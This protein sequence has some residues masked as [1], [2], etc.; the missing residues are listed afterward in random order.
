[1]TLDYLRDSLEKTMLSDVD[2]GAQLPFHGLPVV[3]VLASDSN[4]NEKSLMM[5]RDLGQNLAER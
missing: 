1:M 3:I 5:L 4:L 2:Q